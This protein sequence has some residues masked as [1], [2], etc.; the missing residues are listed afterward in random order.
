VVIGISTGGPSALVEVI[1]RLPIT[2]EVPVLVVQHMPPMFTRLLAERLDRATP[3][4]VSEAAGGEGLGPGRCFIAPGDRHLAVGG[5]LASS[6]CHVVIDDGPRENSCRPAVDVLFRTAAEAYGP[7]LL[8]VVMTGMG[9][10]GLRGAE[11]VIAAGGRVLAQDEA[12]SVVWGMPG[13]VVRA[14]LAEAVLALDDIP[15]EIARRV[16]TH[17]MATV[18]TAGAQR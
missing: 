4:Q 14:G 11:A 5:R 16:A 17:R 15:G 13:A 2:L 9:Q 3:I 8:A 18:P 12:T 1:P 10:D 6:D 7:H